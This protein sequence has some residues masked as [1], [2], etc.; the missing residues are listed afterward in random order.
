MTKGPGDDVAAGCGHLRASHADRERVI[1]VLKAAFVPGQ[2]AKNEFEARIGQT[3]VSGTYADLAYVT[4]GLTE[5]QSVRQPA[6]TQSGKAVASDP[7]RAR[8]KKA[9]AWGGYGIILPGIFAAVIVPGYANIAAVIATTAVVYFA[10][11]LIGS[12]IMLANAEW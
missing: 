8:V 6:R 9:A 4:A 5:A 3:F 11:W 10:F 12:F 1:E 2:L 7:A